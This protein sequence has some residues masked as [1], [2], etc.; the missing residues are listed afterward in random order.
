MAVRRGLPGPDGRLRRARHPGHRRQRQPLQPDRRDRDPADAG[1]RG[2]RRDRRRHAA[3][4][5]RLRRRRAS[6]SSCSA[7]PARSCPGSEWAHVVH[8]HL[9]GLPPRVDLGAEKSLAALLVEAVGAGHQR[10]RPLRRR[11]GPGPG[12]GRPARR[13][14]RRGRRSRAT[15]SSLCSRSRR[16]GRSSPCRATCADELVGLA[17]RHGVPLTPLGQTGGG[18]LS[19]EGQFTIPLDELRATWSATLPTALG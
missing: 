10:P 7:R 5:V 18:E 8:G 14:R 13:H 4:P 15:R 19:V 1:G 2:A 9:G 11:A 6:G 16:R 17:E 3:Y 12:G